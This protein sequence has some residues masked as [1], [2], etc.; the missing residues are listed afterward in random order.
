ME[1]QI[2]PKGNKYQKGE[3]FSILKSNL[4]NESLKKII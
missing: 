4:R 2:K 1:T 3:S